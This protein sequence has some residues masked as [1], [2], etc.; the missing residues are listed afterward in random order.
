MSEKNKIEDLIERNTNILNEYTEKLEKEKST[1]MIDFYSSQIDTYK[2]SLE[3]LRKKLNMKKGKCITNDGYE[4]Q[5]KIGNI[6]DIEEVDGILQ[7]VPYFK[8]IDDNGKESFCHKY[9]FEII[10]GED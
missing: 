6:Y 5:I 10:E 3:R 4:H 2:N 1:D 8:F 9:R 7:G